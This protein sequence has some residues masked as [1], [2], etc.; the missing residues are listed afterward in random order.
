MS[1]VKI[2][3]KVLHNNLVLLNGRSRLP[4]NGNTG[5]Y[6]NIWKTIVGKSANKDLIKQKLL[7][8]SL[9]LSN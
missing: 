8:K 3:D 2:T 5:I 1:S 6:L 7:V 4:L 9:L